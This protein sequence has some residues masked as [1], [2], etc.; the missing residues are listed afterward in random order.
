M[1]YEVDE[2]LSNY[3]MLVC[4]LKV[5]HDAGNFKLEKEVSNY[6]LREPLKIDSQ[7]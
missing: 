1:R 5:Y 6:P 7:S 3:L 4:L 2:F